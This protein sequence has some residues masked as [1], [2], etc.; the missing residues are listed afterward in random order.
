MVMFSAMAASTVGANAVFFTDKAVQGVTATGY[1]GAQ[2]AGSAMITTGQ[3]IS[4]VIAACYCSII[5]KVV[6]W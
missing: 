1:A 4:A 6:E 3:P 2:A 5:W